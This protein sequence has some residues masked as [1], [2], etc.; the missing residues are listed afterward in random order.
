MIRCSN[1]QYLYHNSYTILKV[2]VSIHA[3]ID[4]SVF[5]GLNN[6]SISVA[7]IQWLES[8]FQSMWKIKLHTTYGIFLLTLFYF[9][10]PKIIWHKL[11]D[12]K[13]LCH[14]A[15]PVTLYN[16]KLSKSKAGLNFRI[17]LQYSIHVLESRSGLWETQKKYHQLQPAICKPW[18]TCS[19]NHATL[20]LLTVFKL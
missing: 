16:R 13:A 6:L 5:F 14:L 8:P 20:T 12:G 4:I 9:K 17:D 18:T 15:M 3:K 2:R 7:F 11:W 19:W 1:D 10:C